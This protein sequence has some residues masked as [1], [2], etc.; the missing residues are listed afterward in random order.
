MRPEH[1]GAGAAP[2][3]QRKRRRWQ[4]IAALLA[5]GLLAGCG[6]AMDGLI[7]THSTAPVAQPAE[8][9]A[10]I[11][12]LGP[13]DKLRVRVFDE[14][15]LSGD[16]VVDAGGAVDLPLIGEVAAAGAPVSEFQQRVVERFKDGYLRD[17]KIAIE[18]LTYRPFFIL[19]EVK[20][21]GEYDYKTSLTVQDAVAIAGGYT[22]R[23]R[24]DVAYVR[25]A[26]ADEEQHV[27]LSQ[28]VPVYPGDI[29]RV[30][31]RFF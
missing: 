31:E 27:Q 15:D 26:G 12:R 25:R 2:A 10:S 22:Y 3:R 1:L 5:A 28:R 30:P 6:G 14:P 23:A 4:G 7:A 24:D 9:L 20:S 21:A 18:V 16:F 13:G 19:G 29:I 11:Y 17:P 8:P